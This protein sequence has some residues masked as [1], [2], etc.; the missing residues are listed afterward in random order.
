M[1]GAR[2]LLAVQ[3]RGAG[4]FRAV[5]AQHAIGLGQEAVAPLLLRTAGRLLVHH[6]I[7]STHAA[8][9]FSRWAKLLRNFA[10]FGAITARQ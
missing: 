5:L 7:L 4:A 2:P 1:I 8:R 3:G 10:T 6:L 9:S